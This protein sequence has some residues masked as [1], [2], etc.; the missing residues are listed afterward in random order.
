[1]EGKC[2][3][4]GPQELVARAVRVYRHEVA[5]LGWPVQVDRPYACANCGREIRTEMSYR[6]GR[7]SPV[8][9][10]GSEPVDRGEIETVHAMI[11][12][13]V[14]RFATVQYPAVCLSDTREVLPK[15]EGTVQ[16]G[17]V[18][19]QYGDPELMVG[20]AEHYLSAYQAVMPRGRVPRSVV[21]IMPALHLLV[22]AVELVMKADLMRS[23]DD[24]GNEHSLER[25]YAAMDGSHRSDAE[26]RFSRCEPNAR[27]LAVGEAS[28]TVAGVLGV[29]GRSYGGAS[30]V[31]MDTR[32]YAEPTTKLGHSSSLRG[33]NLVKSNT[34]YPIF[35]PHVVESLIETFRFFEGAARLGRLGADVAAGTQDAVENN[36][37]DW[38]FVPASLGLVVVQVRQ[39]AR[40]GAGQTE[41]P[42]Y[43]RW[44]SRRPAGYATSWM[45]GGSELLFYRADAASP[46]ESAGTIGGVDCRIWRN[47]RLGMHSRDLYRLADAIESGGLSEPHGAVLL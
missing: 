21:E 42:G 25:L 22:M 44:K 9:G 15:G 1:M 3:Q 18:I 41:L 19:D 36:H 28:P 37:G 12:P 11:N 33:A 40:L 47:S 34:P 39:P 2:H 35:L 24:P 17:A 26:D 46:E 14:G 29:Y 20:F 27:L 23:G 13:D 16:D 30:K 4:C 7:P 10:L 32:Y 6:P 38:G 45:Y 5:S 43:S 8:A 31:Y